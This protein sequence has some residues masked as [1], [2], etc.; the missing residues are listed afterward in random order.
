MR[1]RPLVF[2]AIASIC[3]ISGYGQDQHLT[4]HRGASFRE[5]LAQASAFDEFAAQ[6]FASLA[7]ACVHKEYPNKIAHSMNSDADVAPPRKLTPAF[8]GCYDWHS[9]VHGHWLLARLARK[10]PNAPFTPDA[11]AALKQSLTKQNIAGEVAYLN[12]AGRASFERP[13]GLAWLLQLVLELREW[14]KDDLNGFSAELSANLQPLEQAAVQRLSVWLPKL[15]HPVRIG[16]HDQTA[17]AMG[18]MIDYARGTG[19]QSFLN[20]LLARARFFFVNDKNCPLEYEPSGEDFLSPCLAEADVM[21][22]VLAPKEFA[23]WLTKFLPQIPRDGSAAWLL[24][25]KSPDPSDPK[26]GHI[27][28]L[29]LSRAWMLKGIAS[30]LPRN[31]TRLAAL[32]K[33]SAAHQAVGLAAVTGKYYLG[34][35][36]LGSFAVY[37]VTQRGVSGSVK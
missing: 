1:I 20:M 22:R 11:R 17:F 10:F 3:A 12:E 27:D 32:E 14:A 24:P 36:W 6:R 23:E 26:L 4:S 35:H 34:G 29:N 9:S 8:Y 30:G 33:S 7:L 28:G 15:S 16:E 19:D 5:P 2:F 37:L 25:E 18:L 21:R 13:Y 31:D